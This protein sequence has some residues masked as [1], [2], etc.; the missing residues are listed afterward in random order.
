[1]IF[2]PFY[3]LHI[4]FARN[5]I[6]QIDQGCF[7]VPLNGDGKERKEKTKRTK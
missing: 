3:Y 4:H 2:S 5:I 6:F 1:M 7:R